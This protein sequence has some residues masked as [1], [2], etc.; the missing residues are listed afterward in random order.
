MHEICIEMT[1]HVGYLCEINS[2]RKV[3]RGLWHKFQD[4]TIQHTETIC[5]TVNILRQ[6][7][8]Y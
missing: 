5:K 6:V 1:V 3:T 2:A 4:I 7:G 8:H